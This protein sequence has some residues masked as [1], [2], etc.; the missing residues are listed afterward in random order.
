MR[1]SLKIAY[2]VRSKYV[3]G[4]SPGNRSHE[5][6]NALFRRVAEYARASCLVWT[7]TVPAERKELL[8]ALDTALVDDGARTALQERCCAVAFAPQPQ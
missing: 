2:D 8:A 5:V 1:D 3:H 7:Q 4:A 6:L